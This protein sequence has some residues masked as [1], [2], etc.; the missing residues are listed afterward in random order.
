MID[1]THYRSLEKMYLAAPINHIFNPR[2]IVSKESAEIEIE[3]NGSLFHSAGAVHGSIYFKMLDDAAFFAAN[4]IVEKYFVLTHSFTI[5][6]YR[7]V[8]SGRMT[9]Y[10][11]VID[12]T[13]QKI[14]AESIVYDDKGRKIGSGKGIFVQGKLP[15]VEALGYDAVSLK[16]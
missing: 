7:P 2:I 3:I 13:K 1:A 16:K 4:S 5:R 11:K 6:F 14:Q 8:S 12:R 10:G 9:S 15:L